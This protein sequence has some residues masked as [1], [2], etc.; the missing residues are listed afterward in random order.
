MLTARYGAKPWDNSP[1]AGT[2]EIP[3]SPLR[4]IRSIANGMFMEME[5]EG[6]RPLQDL[7]SNTSGNLVL[8]DLYQG[9]LSK[10]ASTLPS[11]YIPK[12]RVE[13]YFSFNCSNEHITYLNTN[14]RQRTVV[15]SFSQFS[16][17][18]KVIFAGYDLELSVE[19]EDALEVVLENLQYLGRSEY[20]AEWSIV[21]K[22]PNGIEFNCVP[23]GDGLIQS[24]AIN[25]E[26]NDYI[27]LSLMSTKEYRML[28]YHTNPAMK[29]VSYLMNPSTPKPH[30]TNNSSKAYH[31]AVIA[32]NPKRPV[33][34]ACG[35]IWTDLLHKTLVKHMPESNKFTG[36][37][38]FSYVEEES[39]MWIRWEVD[40]NDDIDQFVLCSTSPF[41][42]DEINTLK[43]VKLLYNRENEASIQLLGFSKDYFKE[44]TRFKST[45]PVLLY[46]NPRKNNLKRSCE[47]QVINTILFNLQ[48]NEDYRVEKVNDLRKNDDG[49]VTGTLDGFGDVTVKVLQVHHGINKR[50]GKRESPFPI[51]FDIEVI[52]ETPMVIPAVGFARRFGAGSLVPA[53]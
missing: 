9:I 42:P 35:L 3:P 51:G 37:K 19:E 20:S 26:L 28:G 6:L 46:T 12:H 49:S 47:G 50:R 7:N 29:Y 34:G 41:T 31:T 18:D 21:N 33:D 17:D 43:R 16:F 25:T 44:S 48:S 52:T 10:L 27:N 14:E 45:T 13:G 4:L 11:F 39:K 32:F 53:N 24:M 36:S 8:S 22:L 30:K 40:S 1:H 2:V 5:Y 23:S 38:N 15:E